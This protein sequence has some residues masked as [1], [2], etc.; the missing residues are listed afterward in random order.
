MAK[1]M[2]KVIHINLLA[3]NVRETG[4]ELFEPFKI[5][6]TKEPREVAI[7][8]FSGYNIQLPKIEKMPPDFDSALY[9]WCYAIYTAHV[10]KKTL[11][12][13]IEISKPLQDHAMQDPGFV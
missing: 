7:P 3:Y 10:E 2:P 12:E 13:V 9:C 5:M 1:R 6:Y 11:K 4:D 8:N